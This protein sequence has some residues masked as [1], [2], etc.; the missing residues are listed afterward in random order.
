MCYVQK[1]RYFQSQTPAGQY[2]RDCSVK[3]VCF[4]FFPFA[5]SFVLQERTKMLPR[6][7]DLVIITV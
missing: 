7:G 1:V 5:V 3:S 4:I 2:M 6:E